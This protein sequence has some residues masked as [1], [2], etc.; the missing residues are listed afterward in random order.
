M[1]D[2][3]TIIIGVIIQI[4]FGCEIEYISLSKNVQ[5]QKFTDFNAI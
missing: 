4:A 1:K 2:A 3:D 5:N